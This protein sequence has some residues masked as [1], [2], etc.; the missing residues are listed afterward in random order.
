MK[1]LLL[2][3]AIHETRL[4]MSNSAFHSS[5]ICLVFAPVLF[6]RPIRIVLAISIRSSSHWKSVWRIT[7]SKTTLSLITL[8]TGHL[9]G[10]LWKRNSHTLLLLKAASS[11]FYSSILHWIWQCYENFHWRRTRRSFGPSTIG[12]VRLLTDPSQTDWR[13]YFLHQ[14]QLIETVV[15]CITQIDVGKVLKWKAILNYHLCI[16]LLSEASHQ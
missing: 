10:L 7:L 4:L 3:E 16:M 12:S 6:L 2:T 14:S 5:K 13:Y 15:V 1:L 9:R 8:K 11:T